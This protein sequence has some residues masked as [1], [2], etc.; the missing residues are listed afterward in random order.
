MSKNAPAALSPWE[1]RWAQPSLEQLLDPYDDYKR[2]LL[3]QLIENLESFPGVTSGLIWHGTSW[4][5]TLQ[6]NLETSD[7]HSQ[8]LAFLV[9]NRE[10]PLFCVPMT[11]ETIAALPIRRLNRF[12]REG[13]RSARSAVHLYWAHFVPS[14]GTEVEYLTDLIKRLHRQATAEETA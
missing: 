8:P 6:F 14:A 3:R 5:W 2:K 7:G 4:R 13:I 1:N 12:I 10:V 11:A 9:P